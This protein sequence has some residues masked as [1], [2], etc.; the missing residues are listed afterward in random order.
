MSSIIRVGLDVHK[1]SI[2]VARCSDGTRH[3]ATLIDTLPNDY[4][5]LKKCLAKIGP[6][7][8][9][10]VCYEAGPTGFGLARRLNAEGIKCVI[11]A[12]SL[13]PQKPGCRIKTDRRDACKLAELY[14]DNQLTTITIPEEHVEAMRDLERARAAAKKD[15]RVARQRVSK[16]LLRYERNWEGVS[17]WTQRT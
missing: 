6:L 7:D 4:A 10:R 3:K 14:R 2:V 15:E 17:S 5:K 9:L 1:D 8:R 13:I 11:V 12:P 16:F